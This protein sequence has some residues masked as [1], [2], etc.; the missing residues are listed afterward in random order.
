[1]S[2]HPNTARVKDLGYAIYLEYWAFFLLHTDTINNIYRR[3]NSFRE[4]Y[5]C[6]FPIF[7]NKN[8]KPIH[9]S[10]KEHILSRTAMISPIPWH[11]SCTQQIATHA[12]QILIHGAQPD[13]NAWLYYKVQVF[14]RQHMIQI[15]SNFMSCL[16]WN[17][18]G[19]TFNTSNDSWQTTK[20]TT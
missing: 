19:T 9:P 10:F 1:M 15:C 18:Q 13:S 2:S 14:N 20:K 16:R 4:L 11:R 8:T 5:G 6:Q 17:V 12:R 7:F 3:L